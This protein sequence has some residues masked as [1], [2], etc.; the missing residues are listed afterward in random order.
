MSQD[1]EV[2]IMQDQTKIQQ[3]CFHCGLPLNG[4]ELTVEIDNLQQPMC[5]GGCQAVADAII[6]S[7]NEDY[8]AFVKRSLPPARNWCLNF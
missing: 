5:C 7:G 2:K 4:S 6:K 1:T 8:S 3:S